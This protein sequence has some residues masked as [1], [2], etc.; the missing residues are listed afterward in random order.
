MS[1]TTAWAI[2]NR[3]AEKVASHYDKLREDIK[4]EDAVNGDETGAKRNGLP[5]WL[6]GFFS[7]T[8]ALFVFNLTSPFEHSSK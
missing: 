3:T 1:T 5:G 7:L 2:C 8:I 6:W 4:K